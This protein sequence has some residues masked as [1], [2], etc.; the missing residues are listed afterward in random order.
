MQHDM[1]FRLWQPCKCIMFVFGVLSLAP[2][3]S[4]KFERQVRRADQALYP[5]QSGSFVG[6]GLWLYATSPCKRKSVRNEEV[7]H[8]YRCYT[9]TGM[10]RVRQAYMHTLRC[11]ASHYI[12]IYIQ[13]YTQ[14]AHTDTNSK[15]HKLINA[16]MHV[17]MCI[18]HTRI[19]MWLCICA[20][21]CC[22]LIYACVCV[23]V[24]ILTI[25]HPSNRISS[26]PLMHINALII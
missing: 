6:R 8:L 21:A 24:N 4:G 1:K 17:F 14:Y 13:I 26:M 20:C 11:S 18:R 15:S 3:Y 10:H 16:S 22:I 25:A 2:C 7:L 5:I 12:C 23:C 19:N 9:H